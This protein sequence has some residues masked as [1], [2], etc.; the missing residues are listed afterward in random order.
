MDNAFKDRLAAKE[1]WVRLAQIVL[2]AVI[3]YI[4]MIVAAGVAVLQFVTKLVAGA[5]N[6]RLQSFGRSLGVYLYQIV[7]FACFHSDTMPYPFAAWPWEMPD[8]RRAIETTAPLAE[9]AAEKEPPKAKPAAPKRRAP[10][11][12]A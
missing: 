9:P 3:F 11:K 10:R 1:T 2:F 6:V 12:E 8:E 5:A 4:V 7:S